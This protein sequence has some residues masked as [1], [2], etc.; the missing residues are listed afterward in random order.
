[1]KKNTLC[2]ALIASAPLY[3][4]TEA[5]DVANAIIEQQRQALQAAT[6]GKGFGPQSPRDLSLIHI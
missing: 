5:V 2:L 3:A 1:M 6:E 4:A